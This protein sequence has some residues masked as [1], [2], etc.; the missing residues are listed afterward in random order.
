MKYQIAVI[1]HILMLLKIPTAQ[2]PEMLTTL[3]LPHR[4]TACM[5]V[6]I[7]N[8]FITKTVSL[9]NMYYR[10]SIYTTILNE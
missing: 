6:Y 8:I 10:H 2:I 9:S 3:L 4:L 5:H 1:T 7:F